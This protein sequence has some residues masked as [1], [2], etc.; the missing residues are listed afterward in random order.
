MTFAEKVGLLVFRQR[1]A[2]RPAAA[3]RRLRMALKPRR[4][5]S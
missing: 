5:A 1:T 3:D 2:G 4:R